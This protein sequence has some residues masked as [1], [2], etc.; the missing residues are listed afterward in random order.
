MLT[1]LLHSFTLAKI[2]LTKPSIV[3]SSAIKSGVIP[4]FKQV[5]AVI[6]PIQ[7]T[8]APATSFAASSPSRL[9]RLVT[10]EELVKV[11]MSICP[12]LRPSAVF[13][14][15]LAKSKNATEHE[16]NSW[17]LIGVSKNSVMKF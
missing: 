6:G 1:H 4:F 8:L 13:L 9:S 11:I 14:H 7:A 10:V 16:S 17:L 3:Y 15:A 2:A 12:L 5:S